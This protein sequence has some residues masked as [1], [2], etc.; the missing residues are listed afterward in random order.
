MTEEKPTKEEVEAIREKLKEKNYWE[1]NYEADLI[2][3]GF[4]LGYKKG[5]DAGQEGMLLGYE[6]NG[7]RCSL[8]RR[9]KRVI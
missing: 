2:I 6:V 8:V 3:E 5:F 9:K 1:P 4:I 7:I